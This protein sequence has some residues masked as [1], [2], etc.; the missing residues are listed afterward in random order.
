MAPGSLVECIADFSNEREN[1]FKSEK[2]LLLLLP[3]KGEIYTVRQVVQVKGETGLLLDEINNEPYINYQR[4]VSE[5]AFH[6]KC[7]RE[8][9][10]PMQINIEEILTEKI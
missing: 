7:F 8:L 10:G 5:P 1:L 3:V 2:V 6:I 9:Q 4:W